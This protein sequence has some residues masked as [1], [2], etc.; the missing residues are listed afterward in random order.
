MTHDSFPGHRRTARPHP[1]P[2]LRAPHGRPRRRP[3]HPRDP[4]RRARRNTGAAA[5]TG[6]PDAGEHVATVLTRPAATQHVGV[7]LRP[8]TRCM[9]NS[10]ARRGSR[11]ESGA[12]PQR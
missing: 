3:H 4:R 11:C 8:G 5:G 6:L 7:T 2:D 12:A 9:L 1:R 10:A